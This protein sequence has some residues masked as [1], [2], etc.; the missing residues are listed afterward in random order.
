MISIEQLWSPKMSVGVEHIDEHHKTLLRLLLEAKAAV[1]G[2]LD[3]DMVR[4]ILSALT[5]YSKYHFLAEERFMLEEGFP[6]IER[7]RE[8]HRIF[9]EKLDAIADE[10]SR[11][12]LM[13]GKDLIG[14]LKEW[15]TEHI[16]QEDMR[17]GEHARAKGSKK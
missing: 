14:F 11:D 5:G 3:R 12:P 6:L 1:D 15:F 4:G 13:A 2:R 7:Q 10:Y 16:L 9:G 17:I 8:A